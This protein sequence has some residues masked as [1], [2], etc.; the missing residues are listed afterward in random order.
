M[1]RVESP[2]TESATFNADNG[3]EHL[4]CLAFIERDGVIIASNALA[5]RITGWTALDCGVSTAV[6]TIL[7]GA[8][9]LLIS[10]RSRFDC[11]LSRRHGSPLPVNAVAQNAMFKGKPCRLLLMIER[12][13]GFD[14]DSERESTLVEDLLDATPEATAITHRGRILHVNQE[15]TRLFGFSL[16]DCVGR[17]LIEM[18]V[19]EGRMYEREM[20]AHSLRSKGRMSIE[21]VRRTRS[22]V[23]LDVCVL[24]ARVRLGSHAVGT[25]VTYRDIRHQKQEEAR[26]RHVAGHDALTGLPNRAAF[27]EAV[28]QT[29]A[30]LKRRPDRRFAVVFMDLDGFKQVNDTLGH[31]A[32]DALLLTVAD[33]LTRCLR[34]QDAVA[35]FGG[36]EF[37]L[38]LDESG[39][40]AEVDRVAERIQAA[41][42]QPLKL[43]AGEAHVAASMGVAIARPGYTAAEELLSHADTAMY[44]AKTEGGG[45]HVV[46]RWAEAK[47]S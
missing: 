13:Q 20:I 42:C 15:F 45:R 19:P 29:L 23:L 12:R 14:G 16:A 10:G 46:F 9:E 18:V 31:A 26:L 2:L 7:L 34:P 37:A 33:R 32:G 21:T 39:T 40:E 28:S 11:L 4:P 5:R 38:L 22:G 25:L 6:R 41:I 17:E 1:V 35:R 44:Q 27:L 8:Y 3:F 47:A 30:R 36:D 24:I 43:E